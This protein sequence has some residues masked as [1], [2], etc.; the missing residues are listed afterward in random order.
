MLWVNRSHCVLESIMANTDEYM[1]IV[2]GQCVCLYSDQ[3]TNVSAMV[4]MT[5]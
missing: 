2:Q 3:P 4:L 1:C 5:E